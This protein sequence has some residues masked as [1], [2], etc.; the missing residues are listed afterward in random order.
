MT[1]PTRL[2]LSILIP[3]RNEEAS[4]VPTVF[5]VHGTLEKAGIDHEI[6]VVNDHSTDGTPQALDAVAGELDALRIVNSSFPPGFGNAVRA[7]LGVYTGD[8]VAV[9]MGDQSDRPEDIVRYYEK[10]L[11]GHEC[12]FGSRFIRGSEVVNYPL[13]KLL[14]N[15]IANRFI[16]SLFRIPLNDTTN[17]FKAYR[18][19]VI[20][21]IQPLISKHFNLTVEMPLKAMIRGY[22][23]AV[24]P[25]SWH[26]RVTGMSKLKLKEMGSRYLFIVLYL[27]LE[28][29]LSRG[30]YL[31]EDREVVREN[32]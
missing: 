13:H 10:L 23:S 16:K 22:T 27:W 31:R 18:R 19:N 24:V 30:D 9:V 11:E 15:R 8:A 12:V 5:A 3:A 29:L 25:I 28:K 1:A 14:I 4:I 21:G 7:G 2:K 6:V 32:E 20:D 26:G 17:A